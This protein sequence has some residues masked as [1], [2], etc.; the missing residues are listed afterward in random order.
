MAHERI[1]VVQQVDLD[2]FSS[3]RGLVIRALLHRGISS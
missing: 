1:H 2:Y 3:K